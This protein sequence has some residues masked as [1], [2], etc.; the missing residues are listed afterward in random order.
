MNTLASKFFFPLSPSFGLFRKT[1]SDR[2]LVCVNRL[3]VCLW[4]K[5]I[6][7]FS[8]F[9]SIVKIC[10]VRASSRGFLCSN[11]SDGRFRAS[12][13][14]MHEP[15]TSFDSSHANYKLK[16]IAIKFTGDRE[17]LIGGVCDFKVNIK[18]IQ[19]MQEDFSRFCAKTVSIERFWLQSEVS[20]LTQSK[21][22]WQESR[23]IWSWV[24]ITFIHLIWWNSRVD[25]LF[26]TCHVTQSP[27]KI[28]LTRLSR[29]D[30]KLH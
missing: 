7:L 25:G 20:L 23:S 5:N 11:K 4:M 13:A 15:V 1:R 3:R 9:V 12:Q 22:I 24:F 30:G 17:D 29:L 2:L 16:S 27:K 10:H 28:P 14:S 8:F 18:I 21:S 26:L 19:K 6:Y